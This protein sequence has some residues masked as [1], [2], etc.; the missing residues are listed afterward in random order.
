MLRRL[1]Q[2]FHADRYRLD[3]VLRLITP[4]VAKRALLERTLRTARHPH[5]ICDDYRQWSA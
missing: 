5:K 4:S 1:M 2:L 3:F